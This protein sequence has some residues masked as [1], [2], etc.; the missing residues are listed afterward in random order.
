LRG[1]LH[2]INWASSVEGFSLAQGKEFF[3]GKAVLG[4]FANEANSLIATGTK[5]EVQAFA[6]K[7]L[8]E[9]GLVGTMLGA[10]CTVPSDI[11]WERL[12]WVRE[13]AADLAAANA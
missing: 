3:G 4:G 11:S 2:I 1:H 6:R 13:A 5:E 7:A 10:D 8:K 12:E 9:A